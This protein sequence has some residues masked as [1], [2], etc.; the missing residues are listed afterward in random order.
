MASQPLSRTTKITFNMMDESIIAV[1]VTTQPLA[2]VTVT[3]QEPK[4]KLVALAVVEL[5]HHKYV[6][7]PT[8]PL[9]TTVAEL[10]ESPEQTKFVTNTS[11]SI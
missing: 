11:V 6:Y 2:S 4:G 8:P 7:G 3:T 1:S 5:L 10:L 9:T